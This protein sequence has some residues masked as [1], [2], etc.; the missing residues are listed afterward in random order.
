MAR[1]RRYWL[2]SVPRYAGAYGAGGSRGAPAGARQKLP[3]TFRGV[4]H[5]GYAP[6]RW[7]VARC[8]PSSP[9]NE[10]LDFYGK[11]N[12]S[13]NIII[14]E[15]C[16]STDLTPTTRIPSC[17]VVTGRGKDGSNPA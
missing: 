8:L 16:I 6:G 14:Y 3:R 7:Q 2:E 1:G 10:M 17:Y 11:V 12:W 4:R 15:F 5:G 9:L 13:T